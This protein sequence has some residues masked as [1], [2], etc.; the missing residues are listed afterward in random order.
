MSVKFYPS[1]A[2]ALSAE[3][4][5]KPAAKPAS[6]HGNQPA[7]EHMPVVIANP[8]DARIAQLEAQLATRDAENARLQLQN[9][10][11]QANYNQ[12]LADAKAML[13]EKDR[14]YQEGV[15]L[16]QEADAANTGLKKAIVLLGNEKTPVLNDLRQQLQQARDEIAQQRARPAIDS[17][18]KIA[19]LQAQIAALKVENEDL[20]DKNLDLDSE[21]ADLE[22]EN[23]TLINE[24]DQQNFH[25]GFQD[26]EIGNL[27]DWIAY[28][29]DCLYQQNHVIGMFQ[30]WLSF[31]PLLPQGI[32]APYFVEPA[33]EPA[34]ATEPA[35]AHDA[36]ATELAAA[37]EPTAP[38]PVAATPVLEVGSNAWIVARIEEILAGNPE[39]VKVLKNHHTVFAKIH[40]KEIC[41][42]CFSSII[43]INDK[44]KAQAGLLQAIVSGNIRE[45]VEKSEHRRKLVGLPGSLGALDHFLAF[46]P[47]KLRKVS[48]AIWCEKNKPRKAAAAPIATPATPP[49]VKVIC[50]KRFERIQ[51]SLASL[52]ALKAY[53]PDKRVRVIFAGNISL[54][55]R[56][57]RPPQ[58][59]P[60]LA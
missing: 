17:E 52:M 27:S 36:D 38:E 19:A 45:Y 12:L 42:T 8:L 56:T 15:Q 2:A 44:K 43:N 13:A 9:D 7:G 58:K 30:N 18:A 37:P 31:C 51:K 21:N 48:G 49:P 33:P 22:C 25:I 5:A 28:L 24:A 23:A 16:Y 39:A 59:G 41:G 26:E 46:Y 4:A 3:T 32:F 57:P 11:L 47:E 40:T 55:K 53:F 34:D 14:K 6:T 50:K 20:R 60:N 35:T 1:Y 54:R 29:H 10:Q